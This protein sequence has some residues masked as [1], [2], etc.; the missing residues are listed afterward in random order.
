MKREKM[1]QMIKKAAF[2][3]LVGIIM[4]SA[5]P[6]TVQAAGWKHN[7]NGYWWQEN[8]YSYPKNQWK[9]IYGKQ[10][11]F[12]SSGYM[13]TSW[14][15]I[16]G[17]WYYLGGKDDGA[18][19][20]Y[21]QKV[22][23]KYYWLGR[24]GAMRTGW[25]QI[26]GKYYWLGH[27]NDGAMKTGW[28]QIYGKYYWLGHSNDGAMKTGWQTI[29]GKKYYL[30]G[31]NDG[32]MKTEWQKIGDYW[33]YFGGAN[34]GSLKTNTWIGDYYVDSSGARTDVSN[35]VYLLDVLK[36]YKT[37]SSYEECVTQSFS[38]GGNNYKNGFTSY[39][40]G[41][42]TDGGEVT[43]FNLGG[44]YKQISFV[45]GIVDGYNPPF[46]TNIS[47]IADGKETANFQLNNGD[48][49]ISCEAMIN[50]C[51]QL[52]IAIYGPSGSGIY[53]CIGIAELKVK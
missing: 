19:K 43:Y 33:Y 49:P 15:K 27:S 11:H 8:D 23:G 17:K 25:Q 29:Y 44:K 34:D 53:G 7:K 16:D 22:Y 18:K 37:P 47:I 31:A 52:Q 45:A 35:G 48:L 42:Q 38:M 51:K 50:N 13:D 21:W 39:K 10:Y 14:K 9:T 46:A 20:T 2:I 5:I 12:N 4:C 24:D 41:I 40:M 6:I 1:K 26:Y 28:Q 36:P 30:G 32:A 3:F